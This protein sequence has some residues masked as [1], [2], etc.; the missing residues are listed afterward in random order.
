MSG[1]YR[2]KNCPNCGIEHRKR[3]DY[4]GQSCANESR[5]ITDATKKK[6]SRSQLEFGKT[7]EGIAAAKRQSMRA[8]A[9]YSGDELPVTIEDFCVDLPDFPELPE[10]YDQASDW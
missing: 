1:I 2:K 8:T 7:P 9:Y 5:T 3:G 10:G 6:M 4:C